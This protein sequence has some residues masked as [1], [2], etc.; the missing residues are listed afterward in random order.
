MFCTDDTAALTD[1]LLL[2]TELVTALE[3]ACAEVCIASSTDFPDKAA[4]CVATFFK[5]SRYSDCFACTDSNAFLSS[6]NL[7]WKFCKSL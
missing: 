2:A 1:G 6:A 5:A 7:V 4:V 3:A